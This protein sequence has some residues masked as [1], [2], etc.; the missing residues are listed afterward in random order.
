MNIVT[1]AYCL[2]AA[3]ILV[4]SSSCSTTYYYMVRH[5]EKRNAT[6]TST[7]TENGSL[8]AQALRDSLIH[9]GLTDIYASTVL[10]TQL[11]AQPIATALHKPI[12]LYRPDTIA[13]FAA[14]LQKKNNKKILI[15]GHSNTIPE[16]IKRM[17]NETAHIDE[18]D[19]DNL[20][21]LKKKR[22][23]FRTK[24]YL[25]HKTYGAASP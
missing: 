1:K 6:D 20:F 17:A 8:R 24:Y 14:M 15:V 10:R 25:Y 23:L 22:T 5:A 19:F 18:N 3:G 21:I 16:T 9:T 2:L 7:L 4:L 11:T 13:A 12:L